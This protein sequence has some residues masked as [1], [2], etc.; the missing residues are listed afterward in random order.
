MENDHLGSEDAAE[1]GATVDV[2]E[3]TGRSD[4]RPDAVVRPKA[5][6]EHMEPRSIRPKRDDEN[7]LA[8]RMSEPSHHLVQEG[9]RRKNPRGLLPR[10]EQGVETFCS[11][12]D[13]A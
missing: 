13:V 4:H 6:L 11:V 3:S 5:M 12:R 10:E 1:K 7:A 8:G 9:E 2:D